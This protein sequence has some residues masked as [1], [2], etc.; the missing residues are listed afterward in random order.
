MEP[1]KDELKS[2]VGD[3]KAEVSQLRGSLNDVYLPR[4]EA[5]EEQRKTNLRFRQLQI[6]TLVAIVL[7]FAYVFWTVAIASRSSDAQKYICTSYQVWQKNAEAHGYTI[8]IPE[9]HIPEHCPD[10]SRP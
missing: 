5:E 1:T 6:I 4:E 8:H 10:S 7:M 3:L 2:E 9:D